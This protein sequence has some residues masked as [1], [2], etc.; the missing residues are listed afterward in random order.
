MAEQGMLAA[1]YTY[2]VIDDC[3]VAGRNVTTGELYPDPTRF[4]HGMES[5]VRYVRARGLKLG[6]YT[7]VTTNPC[8]HGQYDRERGVVPGSWGHYRADART[9]AGWGVEYVKADFCHAALPNGTAID[10]EAAYTSFS[11]ELV[12]ATRSLAGAHPIYF[13]ASYDRW[14]DPNRPGQPK[15]GVRPPWEWVHPVANAYRL[16]GDHHD[17]WEQLWAEIQGNAHN[18]VHSV[19]GSFGDWD[20][21]ITGGAGCSAGGS[22]PP[23]APCDEHV[24]AVDCGPGG[25]GPAGVR[26]PNM[27]DTEYRTSFSLWVIG[28]SPLMIDADIRNMSQFQRQTLLHPGM[29]ALH[30]DAAAI[31]GSRVGCALVGGLG[32]ATAPLCGPTGGE[33]WAKRLDGNKTAI[34]LVNARSLPQPLGFAFR[35]LG[36]GNGTRLSVHDV[37]EQRDVGSPRGAY[38]TTA[39][40]P[41]HG[42]V[43]LRIAEYTS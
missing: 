9:F 42:T 19:V 22:A 16:G 41:P 6:I 37:W 11:R 26:C 23:P 5:L 15:P 36:Y 20:A 28:A 1:G 17:Q 18:A 14:V 3:W 27:T 32:G 40:V 4:P 13:L 31:G 34:A 21:L 33:V 38:V 29:L 30:A 39:A 35:L 12:A 10:A 8:I 24:G 43:V 7:D 2:L 25:G